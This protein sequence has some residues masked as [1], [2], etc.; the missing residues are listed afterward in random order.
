MKPRGKSD[1]VASVKMCRAA[2]AAER[3]ERIYDESKHT[4]H[5]NDD[6]L[7]FEVNI[8]VVEYHR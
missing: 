8:I 5:F 3:T 1:E 6:V 7:Y 2:M 4:G